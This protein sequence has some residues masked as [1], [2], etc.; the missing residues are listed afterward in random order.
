[1]PWLAGRGREAAVHAAQEC[2]A[3]QLR[4]VVTGA[5]L[6]CWVLGH[7]HG[8][9]QLGE[10]HGGPRGGG[11]PEALQQSLQ[12]VGYDP[13][14]VYGH[15]HGVQALGLRQALCG[16][17]GG[18][19]GGHRQGVNAMGRGHQPRSRPPHPAIT[20]PQALQAPTH[21]SSLGSCTPPAAGCRLGP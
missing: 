20:H 11:R 18:E 8:V 16:A 9:E 19:Q 1:M 17:R 2:R 12:P 4:R 10:A 14:R 21:P 15:R 13:L 3:G 7:R 5:R 6:A